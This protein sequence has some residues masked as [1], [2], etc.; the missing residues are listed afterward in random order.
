MPI[1]GTASQKELAYATSLY[2]LFRLWQGK[3]ETLIIRQ[4]TYK[5]G[6]VLSDVIA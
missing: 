2:S 1:K 3:T 5:A 4:P 6:W